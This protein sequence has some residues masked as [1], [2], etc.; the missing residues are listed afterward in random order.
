MLEST[1]LT[2]SQDDRC[3]IN[4]HQ[5][6]IPQPTST[7]LLVETS[8]FIYIHIFMPCLSFRGVVRYHL[9][10]PI[11][12]I[13]FPHRLLR[14]SLGNQFNDTIEGVR[15]PPRLEVKVIYLAR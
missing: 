13:T 5:D 14:L 8:T 1:V 10:G 3:F 12:G 7:N 6:S 11:T 2:L 9:A 4:S 15:W